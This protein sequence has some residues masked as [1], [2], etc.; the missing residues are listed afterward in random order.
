M[1]VLIMYTVIVQT[2][3]AVTGSYRRVV[4]R[5]VVVVGEL[6]SRCDASHAEECHAVRPIHI[7]LLH[8]AVG[9]AR[10][11][12]ETRKVAHAVAVDDN[13]LLKVETVVVV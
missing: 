5:E 10:V 1:F 12:D 2:R 11:V 6:L 13:S 7:P 8:L 3:I 9:V 4:G